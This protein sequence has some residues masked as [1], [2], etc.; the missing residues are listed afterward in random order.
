MKLQTASLHKSSNTV[1]CA[2]RKCCLL[3]LALHYNLGRCKNRPHN[4]S[5]EPLARL[6]FYCPFYLNSGRSL[7]NSLP[8]KQTKL[9]ERSPCVGSSGTSFWI[10]TT[11]RQWCM[12]CLLLQTSTQHPSCSIQQTPSLLLCFNNLF[13]SLFY[14]SLKISS[15]ELQ[16][17]S[18]FPPPLHGS[19]GEELLLV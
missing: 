18:Y 7:Y 10:G 1:C 16:T 6:Y 4:A 9:V 12:F 15:C 14:A 17:G 11:Q 3:S 13:A 8:F 2:W 5:S 19:G